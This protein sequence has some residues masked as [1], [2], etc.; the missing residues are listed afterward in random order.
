MF[1][2]RE[3]H[4]LATGTPIAGS[5][6]RGSAIG[7]ED[8]RS[9]SSPRR[10]RPTASWR[11]LGRRCGAGDRVARGCSRTRTAASEAA[12]RA[13]RRPCDRCRATGAG[14]PRPR[15]H[16]YG[17]PDSTRSR[18]FST[19]APNAS[20]GSWAPNARWPPTRRTSCG[21]HSPRCRSGS[22]KSLRRRLNLRFA[23]RPPPL[24]YRRNGGRSRRLAAG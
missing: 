4:T 22:R 8:E 5:V 7:T 11:R 24:S 19:A 15:N 17:V 12:R 10:R 3:G 20:A 2:T 13:T 1:V 9:R 6:D 21:V 14:D 16:R 23:K 18:R